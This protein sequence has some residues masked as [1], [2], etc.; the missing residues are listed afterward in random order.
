MKKALHKKAWIVLFILTMPVAI[1]IAW[2]FSYEDEEI[3]PVSKPLQ[4]EKLL[5]MFD[6]G[7]ALKVLR[8]SEILGMGEK[9]SR[10]E[11]N[12]IKA[13]Q[14]IFGEEKQHFRGRLVYLAD[15]PSKAVSTDINFTWYWYW[16]NN[17]TKDKKVHFLYYQPN[18]VFMKA[19]PDDIFL[20]GRYGP[21]MLL[22]I[23]AK[24]GSKAYHQILERFDPEGA[25]SRSGIVM[26]DKEEETV[27]TVIQDQ[28]E[29]TGK[30][31]VEVG[32]WKDVES[33]EVTI[34]GKATRIK[35]GDTLTIEGIFDVRLLGI[36]TPE[37]KQICRVDGEDWMCG[38]AAKK[39]LVEQIGDRVI[40][41]TNKKKGKYG[42]FL[43]VCEVDGVNLNEMMVSKGLAVIYYTQD[44]AEAE[45]QAR[46]NKVGLWNSEFINPADWRKGVR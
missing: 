4:A 21:D 41:C 5:E 14:K 43:S 8:K 44:F 3:R 33:G 42:R 37:K 38:Q 20:V 2:A 32:I 12:G 34:S 46:L 1:G 9:A 28:M 39:A 13:F 19:R 6:G 11:I 29:Q 36:D 16:K 25:I 45:R 22:G 35:D 40:L 7:V 30:I 15:Q 23:V 10:R 17:D 31:P 27:L 24:H 26:D 18:P